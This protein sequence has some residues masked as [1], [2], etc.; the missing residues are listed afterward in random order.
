[1]TGKAG[2][3][4]IVNGPLFHLLYDYLNDPHASQA[5]DRKLFSRLLHCSEAEVEERLKLSSHAERL[6][7]VAD[8]MYRSGFKL[9]AGSLLLSSHKLHPALAKLNSTLEYMKVN[10]K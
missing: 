5:V 1:M 2:T 8:L 9:E 10:L 3:S 4:E 6:K 7:D